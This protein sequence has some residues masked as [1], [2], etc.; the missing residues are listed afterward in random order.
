MI[1]TNLWANQTQEYNTEYGKH[2]SGEVCQMAE[3]DPAIGG[4]VLHCRL[5]VLGSRLAGR[6]RCGH[7]AMMA[8]GWGRAA[9]VDFG[10]GVRIRCWLGWG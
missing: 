8:C 3:S 10:L 1:N 4:L 5:P 7:S 9:S 2:L 6:L